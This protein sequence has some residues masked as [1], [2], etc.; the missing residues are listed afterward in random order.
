M[1]QDGLQDCRYLLCKMSRLGKKGG[2]MSQLIVL[3][4]FSREGGD[5]ALKMV[6]TPLI[7]FCICRLLQ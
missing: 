3:D 7:L 4:L 2:S 1:R 6:S 5:N